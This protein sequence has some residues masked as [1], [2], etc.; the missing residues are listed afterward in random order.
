[1]QAPQAPS[2]LGPQRSSDVWNMCFA[3]SPSGALL[4]AFNLWAEGTAAP[5]GD[6][7]RHLAV[8]VPSQAY[9]TA[10]RL[11]DQGPVQFAGYRYQSYTPAVAQ[12]LIVVQGPQGKLGSFATTMRWAGRD[13]RYL[14]PPE[15]QLAVQ[16]IPDLSG[17]VQWSAF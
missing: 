9:R 8:D 16:I 2:T 14:F 12:I 13:W 17:Y 4:A 1:M 15:G 10:T 3:H 5:S 11:D 6:V 7:Y